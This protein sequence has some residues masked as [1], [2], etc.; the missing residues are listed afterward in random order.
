MNKQTVGV[1]FGSRSAEHDVSIVTALTI[2]KPLERSGLYQPVPIYIAKDGRWFS[3]PELADINLYSSGKI[4][5]YMQRSKP[6]GIEFGGLTLVH[7]SGLRIRRTKIDVAFPATHGTYG[8]DGSLMGVLRMADIPF[9]GADLAPSAIA[10]DKVLCKQVA[11]H[12]GIPVAKWVWF[13]KQEFEADQQGVLAKVKPLKYPLFVKPAH[14]G[15]SIGITKVAEVKDLVNALEV[16]AHYDDRILVEEG[17]SNLIEVTVPVMGNNELQ[18]GAVERPIQ[19]ANGAVFDFESKYMHQGKGGKTGGKRGAQG[20]SEVPAK[21][22]GNLYEGALETAK[23]V[24]RAIGDNGYSRI[25]L[26]IDS[27]TET[28]Y[29][30]EVNPLPGSLYLHNWQAAGMSPI[31]VVSKLIRLAEERHAMQRTLATSFSTNFLKQDFGGQL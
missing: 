7:S 1:F 29:F 6:V 8:E 21:L 9:V 4:E 20:Y 24:Y 15:S 10:M 12:E 23:A 16:A 28:I 17:V 14:L 18:T 27:K 31:Q 26:L 22:P 3:G 25:D 19:L 11:E 5:A 30:N 13:T 2:I